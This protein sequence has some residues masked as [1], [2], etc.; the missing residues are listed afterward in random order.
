[1]V[2]IGYLVSLLFSSY[3]FSATLGSLFKDL[4]DFFNS[5]FVATVGA[6]VGVV[7]ALRFE[8]IHYRKVRQE[9]K[10]LK[11]QHSIISVLGF[12]NTFPLILDDDT[13]AFQSEDLKQDF[14]VDEFIEEVGSFEKKFDQNIHDLHSALAEV[15]M[16]NGD[17]QQID[18]EYAALIEA[19]AYTKTYLNRLGRTLRQIKQDVMQDPGLA[20]NPDAVRK[21]N[22]ALQVEKENTAK[23]LYQFYLEIRDTYGKN[24]KDQNELKKLDGKLWAYV[25]RNDWI[26]NRLLVL[27]YPKSEDKGHQPKDPQKY[28]RIVAEDVPVDKTDSE[29]GWKN[30]RKH[31]VKKDFQRFH[32]KSNENEFFKLEILPSES[33][34]FQSKPF[35]RDTPF[36]T[37][38]K[39]SPVKVS[40]YIKTDDIVRQIINSCLKRQLLLQESTDSNCKPLLDVQKG[41]QYSYRSLK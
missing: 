1:M 24:F 36:L 27:F 32:S 29:T 17:E 12:I 22:S 38:H 10:Q 30:G 25:Q 16:V 33:N 8:E 31:L 15:K 7:I 2:D 39:V 26:L 19:E 4:L 20:K 6:L 18:A 9:E 5:N 3:S 37:D 13:R 14:F 21:F 11:F 23:F 35:R 28:F 41:V 34:N 40:T